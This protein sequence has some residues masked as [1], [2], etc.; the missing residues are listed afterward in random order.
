MT[1]VIGTIVDALFSIPLLIMTDFEIVFEEL[2]QVLNQI[3]EMP[4]E[5]LDTLEAMMTRDGTMVTLFIAGV[6]FNLVAYSLIAMLGGAIGVAIFE[7][8]KLNGNS[9]ETTP[10]YRSPTDVPPPPPP[11]QDPTIS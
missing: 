8:R 7:K 1:G 5:T 9:S 11:P 10:E 4:P 3:P 2:R 6:I